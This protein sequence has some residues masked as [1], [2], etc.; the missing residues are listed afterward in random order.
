MQPPGH[1]LDPGARAATPFP[2]EY[3]T[4]NSPQAWAAGAILLLVT[5]TIGLS[6]DVPARVVR[7]RP[8]LPARVGRLCLTGLA[9]AGASRTI[10]VR[11]IEGRVVASVEGAPEG[12]SVEG[13]T[14]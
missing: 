14:D 7:V 3:P 11:T 10:T 6:I 12:F 5:T 2:V 4:S 9:V 8:M 1:A 13:A